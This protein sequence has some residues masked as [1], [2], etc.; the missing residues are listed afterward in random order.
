[1]MQMKAQAYGLAKIKFQNAEFATIRQESY[2]SLDLTA[3][4]IW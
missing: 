4:K 2:R 3:W 1:M